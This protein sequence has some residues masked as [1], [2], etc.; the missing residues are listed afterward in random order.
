MRVIDD[1]QLAGFPKRDE[2]KGV[3]VELVIKKDSCVF[4]TASFES[5]ALVFDM[6]QVFRLR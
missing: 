6:H 2:L 4:S 1:E 5:Y 3:F